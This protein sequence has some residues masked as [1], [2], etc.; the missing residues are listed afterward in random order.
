MPN[1]EDA[2]KAVREDIEAGIGSIFG[3]YDDSKVTFPVELERLLAHHVGDAIAVPW[4]YEA[5]HNGD[6]QGLLPTFRVIQVHGVTI[7]NFSKSTEKPTL[8][9]YVDWLGVVNQLGLV[10][11]WRVP[12]DEPEYRG[13][14]DRYRELHPEDAYSE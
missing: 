5:E 11:S 12:V 7:V 13:G 1:F 2:K 3:P 4:M 9:R 6:F 10:V 14:K 8:H